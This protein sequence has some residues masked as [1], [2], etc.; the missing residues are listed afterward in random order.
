MSL[1]SMRI[2]EL[3]DELYEKMEEEQC[4][5]VEELK[6]ATAEEV[7]EKAYEYVTRQDIL[8]EMCELELTKRQVQAL[9]KSPTPLSDLY[10]KWE[11]MKIPPTGEYQLVIETCANEK[12]ERLGIKDK[13]R[14]RDAR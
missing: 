5:Y 13:S 8:D 9:L 14:D 10:R 12:A 2:E 11:S 3:H 6:T 4:Q 1:S 7:L